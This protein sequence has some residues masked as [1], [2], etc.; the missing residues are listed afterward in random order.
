[1]YLCK[2]L[3]CL[4]AQGGFLKVMLSDWRFLRFK[5]ALK[6]EMSPNMMLIG[7]YNIFL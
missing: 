3:L 7:A 1:M 4:H 2:N 5:T 6:Q